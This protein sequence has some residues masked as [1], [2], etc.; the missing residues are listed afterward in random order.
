MREV[1]VTGLGLVSSVG[2][3][4]AA[5][6][7]RSPRAFAPRL[8]TERFAPYP[9]HPAAALE[10]DRQIPKKA[11]PAPDGALAEA[12]RLRGRAGARRGRAKTDA[13]LRRGCS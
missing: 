9:V 7:R 1:V 12:R 3:G 4:V 11:R 13:A 6:W 10:L 5:H 8:D 2:E